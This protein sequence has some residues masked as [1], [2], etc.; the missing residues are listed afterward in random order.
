VHDKIEIVFC[1]LQTSKLLIT[2]FLIDNWQLSVY[3][4]FLETSFLGPLFHS[5]SSCHLLCNPRSLTPGYLPSRNAHHQPAYVRSRW[6]DTGRAIA[7]IARSCLGCQRGK[8]PLPFQPATW[9]NPSSTS[10]GSALS[11][12]IPH[13]HSYRPSQCHQ[14]VVNH[15]YRRHSS[16]PYHKYPTF[17]GP[18][19]P[20]STYVRR[21]QSCVWR[22]PKYWPPPPTPPS[23]CVL[24]PHQRQ[25]AHTRRAVRGNDDLFGEGD[26]GSIFW[27][28]PAIGLASYNNL[29]TLSPFTSD[30]G[31]QFTSSSWSP[32]FTLLSIGPCLNHHLVGRHARKYC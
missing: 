28:T 16:P 10:S 1:E 22:L 24:P 18:C 20:Q 11:R 8:V 25:G 2:K 6:A 3:C 27:K 32:F 4:T 21:V 9:T 14:P 12:L 13:S 23:E 5:L 31:P 26:G 19:H 7:T 30:R 29:S 15:R 17:W